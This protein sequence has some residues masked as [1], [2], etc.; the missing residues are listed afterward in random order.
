MIVTVTELIGLLQ[1]FPGGYRVVVQGY[2]G[3]FDDITPPMKMG[4]D[5]DVNRCW[6]EG[7]HNQAEGGSP[8]VLIRSAR[9]NL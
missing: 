3:G 1:K 2:E 7:S 4:L 8:A 5:L 9:K 6:F